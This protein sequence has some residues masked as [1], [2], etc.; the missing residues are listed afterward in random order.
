MIERHAMRDAAAAVLADHG[1]LGEPEVAHHVH[2]VLRH[3]ALRVVRVI[4]QALRLAAVAVAAQ[5]RRHDRELLRE[6]R[7]DV[8]PRVV[9][10]RRTM[11]QQQGRAVAALH[12]VNRRAAARLDVRRREA[13]D[14]RRRTGGG[15]TH[16]LL[17]ACRAAERLRE[18]HACDQRRGGAQHAPPVG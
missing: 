18:R 17:R 2:L 3:R 15:G 10:E 1:E 11:Q 6:A 8:A 9:R 12:G 13:R 5:I 16:G 4:G 7:R 14:R